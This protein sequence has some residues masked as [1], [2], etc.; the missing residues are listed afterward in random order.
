MSAGTPVTSTSTSTSTI[1]STAAG[2]LAG[3]GLGIGWRP[4]IAGVIEDL[5][6]LR[7]CEVV[8]E[9]LPT[10][11]RATITV[12]DAL[13]TLTDRGVAVVPH[14]VALSLGSADGFQPERAVRLAACADAL[15]A[16]VASEHIAFVRA[17]GI[18]AGHLLPI[19]RTRP[20]LAVM[21]RNVRA[22]QAELGV[23]LAL[24][25]IAALLDWPEADYTEAEFLQELLEQT[26]AYLLLD[27]ANLYANAL[28]HGRDALEEL[29]RLPL[30]RIAYAHIAGGSLVDG[31]Y[32]D[33]HTD[34]VP[35]EVLSLA[36][37]LAT[38]HAPPALML[39]R[40]GHYPPG[41]ELRAELD[42]IAS[43]VGWAAIT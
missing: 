18:E 2:P 21:V 12:P 39:E 27:V 31:L 5:P 43:A 41:P 40:D 29:S 3:R 32:H 6:G 24:E 22:T 42:A 13:R 19:P 26:S 30:E 38:R 16:P 23:P 1:A 34:P 33:T 14:G 25:P 9:S 35:A 15:H 11:R 20:A 10:N 28:N 36:H 7:F 17:G 8:A 4:E 37:E